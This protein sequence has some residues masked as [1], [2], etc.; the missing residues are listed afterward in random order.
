MRCPARFTSLRLATIAVPLMIALTPQVAVAD[1]LPG[2]R[3]DDAFDSTSG[4][5]ITADDTIVDPINSFRTSGG[6]ENGHTLMRNGGLNSVSFI[7]FQTPTAVSISGIRMFAQNDG[8]VNGFR[9]A[10]NR[11]RLLADTDSN[12]TYETV[13]IDEP[14]NPDYSTE[15]GNVSGIS[16]GLD[17]T[18]LAATVTSQRWRLEVTQGTNVQP[19][20]GARVVEV[21]AVVLTDVAASLSAPASVTPGTNFS[22]TTT[23]ANVGSL[24][25]YSTSLNVATP[26]GLSF[27]SNSGDCVTAF[28]CSFGTLAVGA[29]RT[30]TTTYSV[31]AG[32]LLPNPISVSASA[33]VGPIDTIVANNTSSA[34]IGVTPLANV[35]VSKTGP[36]STVPGTT[37][38]YTTTV[39]NAGPSD[40][41]G[42]VV[43]DPTPPGLVFVSNSVDCVSAFPCNLGTITVGAS[44]TIVTTFDV[45]SS[46]AAPDPV[47]NT[48]SVT[49]PTSDPVAGNN[50]STVTTPLAP[51]ADLSV[52][53]LGPA[54]ITP[55]EQATYTITVTNNGPSDA[56][57]VR[58]YDEIDY[59]PEFVS[60]TG[61][62]TTTFPCLLGTVPSGESRVVTTTLYIPPSFPVDELHN[63]ATVSS[64]TSDPVPGNNSAAVLSGSTFVAD[65]MLLLSAPQLAGGET[66][67]FGIT[68]AS[69]G[70]SSGRQV[71]VVAPPVPGVSFVSAGAPCGGGFPCLISDVPVGPGVQ[72]DAT[73]A[74]T[75]IVSSPLAMTFEAQTA[76]IDLDEA[77]NVVTYSTD[78]CPSPVTLE[79]PEADELDVP[80]TGVLR[81]SAINADSYDVY[82]G[83]VG[84]GCSSLLG[85]TSSSSIPYGNLARRKPYE[86]RVVANKAGCPSGPV[87]SACQRFD[88]GPPCPVSGPQLKFPPQ[89]GLDYLSPIRF[90]WTE[91]PG[92]TSYKVWA[93]ID[94]TPVVVLGTSTNTAFVYE[95]LPGRIA[96]YVEAVFA[97]CP[98]VLSSTSTFTASGSCVTR[99]AVLNSPADNETTGSPIAFDWEP[100]GGAVGYNVWV[101]VDG[102]FPIVVA[103]TTVETEA[104]ARVSSGQIRWFVESRFDR[105]PPAISE[106]R[107]IT[108]PPSPECVANANPLL[109]FPLEGAKVL[110]PVEFQWRAVPGAIGYTLWASIDGDTPSIIASTSGA[111]GVTQDLRAGEVVWFVQAIFDQCPSTESAQQNFTIVEAGS[112]DRDTPRLVSPAEGSTSPTSLVTYEWTPVSGA[113]EYRLWASVNGGVPQLLGSTP[114]TVET[115]EIPT[116]FGSIEWY[117]EALF[118]GCPSTESLR[119]QFTVLVSSSCSRE[120]A[121]LIAPAEGSTQLDGVDIE[122]RWNEVDGALAYR[123][124]LSGDSGTPTLL[125]TTEELSFATRV[126]AGA[127]SWF[128]ETLVNGC[129]SVSSGTVSFTAVSSCS[130]RPPTALSPADGAAELT[131]PIT[132]V[133]TPVA[134]ATGYRVWTEA[135]GAQPYFITVP[136]DRNEAI[137]PL[138]LGITTWWIEASVEGCSGLVS[139]KSGFRVIPQPPCGVPDAPA[140]SAVAEVTTGEKFKLLW[141]RVA[142]ST[143]YEVQQT[144]N[145]DAETGLPDFAGSTVLPTTNFVEFTAP[146]LSAGALSAKIYFR[147]RGIADCNQQRGP[148]SRPVTVVITAAEQSGQIGSIDP[149]N[150]MLLLCATDQGQV[151]ECADAPSSR[152]AAAAVDVTITPSEPW[153]TA[154]PSSGTIPTGGSLAITLAADPA[155]LPGG[156]SSAVLDIAT[157]SSSRATQGSGKSSVGVSIGLAAPVT[158]DPR[159]TPPPYSLVVPAVIHADSATGTW[160]SDLRVANT[161]AKP[162]KYQLNFTPSNVDGTT[163]GKRAVVEVAAGKVIAFDD[164]VRSWYGAARSSLTGVIEIRPLTPPANPNGDGDGSTLASSRT[165]NTTL[166]GSFGQFIPAIPYGSFIGSAPQPGVAS[167]RLSMQHL[168]QSLGFRTNFGFVEGSGQ[169]A[170]ALVRIFDSNGS[171][172]GQT[173]ISLKAGQHLQVNSLLA[174]MGITAENARAEVSVTSLAGR[175]T[176]YAS[177]VDAGTSDPTFVPAVTLGGAGAERLVLPGIADFASGENRWRSDVSIF[178]PSSEAISATMTFYR[179]GDP[180]NPISKLVTIGPGSVELLTD[181]LRTTFGA[182]DT[183]GALHLTTDG[184]SA[185]V[186]TARTYNQRSAGS[187]GQFIPAVT[188]AQSVGLGG[189][190]LQIMQAEESDRLRCNLGITE[191]SGA[192]T[193]VEV[194]AVV[195]RALAAPVMRMTLA[196]FEFRQINSV[197]R[198]MGLENVFNGRLFVRVV[199]GS[200]TVSAYASSID[201]QSGDPAYIPAQ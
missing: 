66:L 82:L 103:S 188:S 119:S 197:F 136:P 63:T 164:I 160:Q 43:Q 154:T 59:G 131:S 8:A 149:I 17:L 21:D 185:L 20:E 130:S 159:T 88:S 200:G 78:T 24:P 198:Q 67:T 47:A 146:V 98:S 113:D 179:Q 194:A 105:C 68:V 102:K 25:A 151:F 106:I 129:P 73:F 162:Q 23:V 70:P 69:L 18:R 175:V 36:P 4:T 166:S 169:P 38:T 32:Y 9:R 64:A 156:T 111:L 148:Y 184:E 51:Q 190:A 29:T 152:R 74:I 97:D 138:P 85:T 94:D 3:S 2:T 61:D 174:Q 75:G 40:A 14:V 91:V 199:G 45:P 118:I 5:M 41:Q 114:A 26:A 37:I 10:M 16:A 33:S 77:N 42:V 84:T 71:V 49:S 134:G 137:I 147:V 141:D 155:S 153:L 87:S 180:A 81:W 196:P 124:W 19:F 170:D 44:R 176:A 181:I 177:V 35:G 126:A 100:V 109:V 173:T 60:N 13:M 53:K 89:G 125:T 34:N 31:P 48:A 121:V 54:T 182:T 117:V 12:G 65:V 27:V 183:G 195:P 115:I 55:G 128:V 157:A 92:A 107:N 46:Y 57:D 79:S 62:C 192:E 28:P 6:F 99:P 86:W 127:Y 139:S 15:P 143:I 163:E 186:A 93:S 58:L 110:S 150:R 165:Y 1:I 193:V 116:P 22:V 201:N 187:L 39:T 158:P 120:P 142:G 7:Q 178:N 30:V 161:T 123:L 189:R 11:F 167:G 80:Q 108:V 171:L 83:P 132:F 135:F 101:S 112:C 145:V 122:F 104:S 144:S 90:E 56:T 140:A 168:S 172:L 95:I 76:S 191:M 72:F 50:S 96:W 52:L 133:W